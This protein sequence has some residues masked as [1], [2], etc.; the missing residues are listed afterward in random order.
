MARCLLALG[1]NLGDRPAILARSC[2]RVAA[3]SGCQLL[4]RSR[5]H[6]TA[7]IG[8]A[9]GQ[10]TFLNG[11]LLVET[12]LPPTE[13]AL[14]LQ[15]IETE[16]GRERVARWDARMIDIDILLYSTAIIDTVDL[17]VPHPRMAVR[18]FVL[19]PATE[20]AGEMLH[21]S[22]GWTL[23]ALLRH[24]RNSPRYVVVTAEEQP[25]ADWLMMHLSQT[26]GCPVW[27]SADE[28]ANVHEKIDG[29]S[30]SYPIGGVELPAR[31]SDGPP[32]VA[33]WRPD[34]LDTVA[35]TNKKKKNFDPPALVIALDV[36]NP[37]NLR[38]AA[39]AAG[40]V[41]DQETSKTKLPDGSTAR[42]LNPVGLGPLARIT[43]DDPATVVQETLAAVR[44]VW[45]DIQI[46]KSKA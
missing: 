23:S 4:A 19:E 36:A 35:A 44:C 7:P 26:I 5:W 17:I 25:I 6:A 14:A 24:L 31:L 32:V 13:L 43:V 28:N 37:R 39:A 15:E 45:P 16:L 38:A 30:V 3:L 20:I 27:P 40:F 22:S 34:A 11:A 42:R 2:A 12:A 29:T 41:V 18:L 9:D 21:P 8:G 10:D 46:P 1:S 33:T